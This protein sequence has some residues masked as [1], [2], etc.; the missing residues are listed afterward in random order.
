MQ[1]GTFILL[2][3]P[4]AVAAI[5]F[6]NIAKNRIVKRAASTLLVL[7]FI[8]ATVVC[9]AFSLMS[10]LPE[11]TYERLKTNTIAMAELTTLNDTKYY[12]VEDDDQYRYYPGDVIQGEL[13]NEASDKG[14]YK[15]A[16]AQC[17]INCGD[18]IPRLFILETRVYWRREWLFLYDDG[19]EVETKYQFII[20]SNES[21]LHLNNP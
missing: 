18:A 2:L 6:L 8:I 9:F 1:Y 21:I 4:I 17:K 12:L 7:S 19:I 11:K 5:L 13:L 15:V 14:S 3:A 16:T 20:P 10:I